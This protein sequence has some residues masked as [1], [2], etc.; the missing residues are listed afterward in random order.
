MHMPEAAMDP[1]RQVL[2]SRHGA[3]AGIHAC[4]PVPRQGYE[5]ER[6]AVFEDLTSELGFIKSISLLLR[7]VQR[8][9]LYGAIP[10][11]SFT[12]LSSSLHMRSAVQPAG[13]EQLP[14][15]FEGNVLT[16]RF[17]ILAIIGISRQVMWAIENPGR[18]VIH[19]H[20]CIQQ[21]LAPELRPVLVKWWEPQSTASF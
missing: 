16:A 4:K 3:V 20:E 17:A 8:G 19:L 6:D 18:T 1:R 10:C 5:R 7:V 15:V 2:R 14:F 11:A 21:L 13:C 12:F 9:L